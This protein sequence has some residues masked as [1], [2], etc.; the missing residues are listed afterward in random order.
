MLDLRLL[1][2]LRILVIS[3]NS[4]HKYLMNHMRWR[5]TVSK[6]LTIEYCPVD[7]NMSTESKGQFSKCRIVVV[8]WL[9]WRSLADDAK[10]SSPPVDYFCESS[11]RATGRALPCDGQERCPSM[12]I[13]YHPHPLADSSLI[14]SL[15]FVSFV[16]F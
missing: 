1:H 13:L 8:G 15:V 2:V 5:R 9:G 16:L 3:L 7:W 11:G 14:R 6:N 4:T 10:V 12:T